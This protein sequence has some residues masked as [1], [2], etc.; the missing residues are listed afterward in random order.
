METSGKNS[1]ARGWYL[2]FFTAVVLFRLVCLAVFVS[3][4]F[5]IPA[6]GDRGLY[7][8]LAEGIFRGEWFPGS[9]SFMPLYPVLLGLFYKLIGSANPAG[10]AIAQAALD[11]CTCIL[12]LAITRRHSGN[13][14]AIAA[15]FLYLLLG[16]A[17]AYSPVTTPVSLALF[18]IAATA[19]LAD[20]WRESW[21][22]L[23]AAALGFMLGCGGQIIGAF[24]LM[25]VP[26]AVWVAIPAPGHAPGANAEAISMFQQLRNHGKSVML[27]LAVVIGAAAPV[28]P[29]LVHNYRIDGRLAPVSVHGGMNIYMGNNP[30]STGYAS[31]IPGLRT[32]AEEMTT[33]S[34]KLAGRLA[35]RPLNAAEASRFW[36]Q[37]ALSFW[38][39]SPGRAL[40]LVLRKIHRIASI[41]DFDDTGVARVLPREI[42][43]L[44]P[45]FVNFGIIWICACIGFV[46]S[47]SPFRGKGTF[48]IMGLSIC[49]AM[50]AAFVTARYRMPLAVLLIPP[51][52][53]GI[54]ALSRFIVRR[55][56]T[57]FPAPPLRRLVPGLALIVL[58]LVPHSVPP[59]ETA[60]E[61][62]RAVHLLQAGRAAEAA[63]AVRRA[64]ANGSAEAWFI[65][66]NIGM[67]ESNYPGALA[68]YRRALELQGER[69]DVLFNAALA[70]ERMNRPGEA[71]DLYGRIVALNPRNARAWLG[72]AVVRRA[73]GNE[74]AAKEALDHAASIAGPNHPQILEFKSGG[75]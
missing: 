12:L 7:Q 26:F 53:L 71:E 4:P 50:L 14:G 11:G 67:V 69:E 16:T 75:K 2:F 59:T 34:I 18:W 32:S 44:R 61:L 68:C 30:A 3:S 25:V 60:D 24:W 58:A 39:E 17:A 64:G 22:Y 31:A 23:R 63:E 45:A 46:F 8:G 43:C 51:A 1:T 52:A 55:E 9:I 57:T 73:A 27:A 15:G 20:T 38:R 66:G 5:F 56:R 42:P 74:P 6:G 40:A 72:L 65:S 48:W 70:L 33:D 41:R 36:T 62:N 13:A 29:S 19:A 47:R 10:A 54:E 35:G 37:K 21:T 49:A 28:F